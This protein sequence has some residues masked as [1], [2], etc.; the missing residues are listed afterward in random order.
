MATRKTQQL[1]IDLSTVQ[2]ATVREALV[3]I[4][5]FVNELAGGGLHTAGDVVAK[6][7]QVTS[8]LV[9]AD[10]DGNLVAKTINLHGGGKIKMEVHE[11][12]LA[13]GGTTSYTVK[14]EILAAIGHAQYNGSSEWRVMGR[15]TTTDSCYFTNG[16]A[17]SKKIHIT[18]SD[19]SHSNKYR[20]VIF[21]RE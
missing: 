16:S 14:G 12:T 21:W 20:V 2:E 18:N 6:K 7:I 15:G 13:I 11:G 17:T 4:L 5:R 10:D 19:A 8:G 1:D 3:S 9:A